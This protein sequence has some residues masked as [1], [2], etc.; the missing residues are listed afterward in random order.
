MEKYVRGAVIGK[1][2]FG[3]A[4]LATRRSDPNGKQYVI[5]EIRMDPR[6]QQSA[7]R[8]AKLLA[9]LDHP[10]IIAC[11]ESFLLPGLSQNMRVL[12]IVTEFADG[13]DLRKR[14]TQHTATR[15][16]MP[17]S[18]V[19]DI[20]VQTCLAL[21]HLHDRK[22]I[23]RD[24]KPEN[25]FLMRS[26]V[27]KL[28]DLGVATVLSNT[29]ACAETL[30]GTP[31]YTSPEIVLE[32]KYNHKTDV[33]SLGCVLYEMITLTH[34]FNGR[35]QRQLFDNIVR[36]NY[37]PIAS[38][39]ASWVGGSQQRCS[40]ELEAL[41]SEMLRKNPRDR[42]SVN[43]LLR[44]PIVMTRIQKFLSDRAVADELNHTVL[45][46]HHIFQKKT[47]A[48]V[49]T[50]PSVVRQAERV[51]VEKKSTGTKPPSVRA[52]AI[53]SPQVIRKAVVPKPKVQNP[54]LRR[55]KS[56]KKP[57]V[58]A[59]VSPVKKRVVPTP[60]TGQLP[61][62]EALIGKRVIAKPNSNKQND[63]PPPPPPTAGSLNLPDR[64]AAF[65]AQVWIDVCCI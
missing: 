60:R 25:I 18:A 28:G 42:P 15:S 17:E 6:D 32:K 29:L 24:I 46:G 3:C 5:K 47:P 10:N 48:P 21:K 58:A 34:A 40:V 19:L 49:A 63:L 50:P 52:A 64:I 36:A 54:L 7:M 38:A 20:F 33:W 4:Y 56:F 62:K 11:K 22:I 53:A 55:S 35:S 26:N 13:G 2:S 37:V 12:C 30:T 23:H 1:G 57:V 45:H 16:L 61:A 44:K 9:A 27:V 14:L 39:C 43:Q 8:E 31:Y 65:N 41:A 51:L 59:V